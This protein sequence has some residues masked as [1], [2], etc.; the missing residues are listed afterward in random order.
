MSET[1]KCLKLKS[2]TWTAK[3][4][5]CFL[6]EVAYGSKWYTYSYTKASVNSCSIS[7]RSMNREKGTAKQH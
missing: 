1:L 4:D 3:N 6:V 5:L 7:L 2:V